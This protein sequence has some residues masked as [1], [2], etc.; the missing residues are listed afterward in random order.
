MLPGLYLQVPERIDYV[1]T[2]LGVATCTVTLRQDPNGRSYSDHFAV[3]AEL[4]LPLGSASGGGGGGSAA[5]LAHGAGAAAAAEQA[6]AVPLVARGAA[7]EEVYEQSLQ[8]GG[9]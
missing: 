5:N 3:Q 8:V 1:L 9:A 6:G 7:A 4:Q 2:T